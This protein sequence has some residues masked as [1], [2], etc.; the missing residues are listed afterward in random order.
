MGPLALLPPLKP[1][2]PPSKS[3]GLRTPSAATAR[4]THSTG[5]SFFGLFAVVSTVVLLFAVV[6]TETVE[7]RLENLRVRRR[8]EI[9]T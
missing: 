2:T 8:N 6:S 1:P 3:D 7:K 9:C 5:L 4:D